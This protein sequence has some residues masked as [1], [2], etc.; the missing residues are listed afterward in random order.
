MKP[1]PY[2]SHPVPAPLHSWAGPTP[3]DRVVA[4]IERMRRL[5]DARHVAVMPDVHLAHGVCVGTVLATS[6]LLYPGAVG[7]DIGCG[8]AALGF[9]ADA[10]VLASA[11]AG[12]DVLRRLSRVVPIHRHA[13]ALPAVFSGRPRLSHPRL[14][15]VL[16]GD[17][18][19]QLGTLGGGN[20][21][22][23]LQR[24]VADGRL[25][26]MVH[27]GSRGLGQSV[28]RH[29]LARCDRRSRGLHVLDAN[30]PAGRAFWRDLHAARAWARL[31]RAWM[32]RAAAWV[33]HDRLGVSPRVGTFAQCDHNHIRRELHTGPEGPRWL[34]VHRKGAAPAHAGRVGL[35][36]GSMGTPSFHVVGRG[37]ADALCSSSHG[38]G[39]AMSRSE[40]RRVV[41]TSGLR[42]AIAGVHVNPNQLA[43]LREEA[44]QAYKG[45]RK[46]MRYQRD[47]VT[48]LR[49]MEPVLSYKGG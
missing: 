32:V 24:D 46:V 30:T 37:H 9:D 1:D 29:H 43:R 4:S 15:A 36:P 40:A 25:W 27:S 49:E 22:L 35:I 28:S 23:E 13:P 20:H 26:L 2:D 42:R 11:A 8:M 34:Y 6:R 18:A 47:L 10:D 7:G 14:D 48:T 33:L 38:A 39:R 19:Q 44:P 31:N 41:S 45:I 5:D 16:N 3:P 12:R 17:A 21:F